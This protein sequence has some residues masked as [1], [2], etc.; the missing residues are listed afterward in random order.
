MMWI[1]YLSSKCGDY[2]KM[3][4]YCNKLLAISHK[5]S[6]NDVEM[7]IEKVINALDSFL[8]ELPDLQG[9]MYKKILD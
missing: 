5:V 9:K 3:E 1:T 6:P 4:V 2:E 8:N 7:A